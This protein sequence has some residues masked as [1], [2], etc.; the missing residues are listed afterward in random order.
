MEK[1]G[2][3][4]ADCY[5]SV[6]SLVSA[7]MPGSQRKSDAPAPIEANR[8]LR[9]QEISTLLIQEGNLD[10]LYER[11]VEA[12][13][14]GKPG[15]NIRLPQRNEPIPLFGRGRLTRRFTH[16]TTANAIATIT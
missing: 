3:L 9:L 2:M 13:I 8:S 15:D 1:G 16:K 7:A 5:T 6:K 10:A 12:A 4:L 14:G 11:V